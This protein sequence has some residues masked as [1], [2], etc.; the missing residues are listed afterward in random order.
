[1]K[2]QKFHHLG[3]DRVPFL[4][5]L[6]HG[7]AGSWGL[8]D[9]LS[10][11]QD[12]FINQKHYSTGGGGLKVVQELVLRLLNL[13]KRNLQLPSNFTKQFLEVLIVIG[14]GWRH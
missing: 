13:L 10:W 14:G 3:W 6:G 8:P 9:H 1:M 11:L 2:E 4:G 12:S 7:D 5:P